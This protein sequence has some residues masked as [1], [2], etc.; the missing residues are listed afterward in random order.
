MVL[1]QLDDQSFLVT[2]EGPLDLSLSLIGSYILKLGRQYCLKAALR[3]SR[4]QL[5]KFIS[6]I[7]GD[8][9]VYFVDD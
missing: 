1:I 4:S 6:E 7:E 9:H 3:E 2:K 8:V 5:S